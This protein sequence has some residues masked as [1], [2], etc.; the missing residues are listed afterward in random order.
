MVGCVGAAVG[1]AIQL[2]WWSGRPRAATVSDAALWGRVLLGAV[3]V[4][5]LLVVVQA[6]LRALV[7]RLWPQML[8]R[9]QQRDALSYL[10]LLL[11][12][13]TAWGVRL[14]VVGMGLI[15]LLFVAAQVAPLLRGVG[16]LAR[17]DFFN[18]LTYLL[19][20]FLV[21][22]MAA[23]IYQVTWQRMLYAAFGIDIASVTIIVSAFMAGLGLGSLAGGLASRR[24]PDRLPHL[25]FTCEVVIGSFGLVS[26]SLIEWTA[27]ATLGA[28]RAGVALAVFLLLLLPTLAM[29][30][31]LPILV[32][33]L[34]RYYQN[35]GRSVGK[36]YFAN[37]LGS[38]L[39]CVLAAD[40]L[41]VILD[42]DGVVYVAA[43]LNL[44][45]G[46]LVFRYAQRLRA[47]AVAP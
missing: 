10:A 33:H 22:G 15:L 3:G 31:T 4:A 29:G 14:T 21:S 1:A 27:V 47:E 45:V 42:L 16:A 23:L 44:S 8:S 34:H 40:L 41:F 37:T 32:S 5:V 12:L 13:A 26:L 20:L 6:G 25:F 46:A 28:S 7:G 18:S 24:L 30:A 17:Q 43:A 36:L 2:A 9:Y 19:G 39:A 38:A 35:V 11:V